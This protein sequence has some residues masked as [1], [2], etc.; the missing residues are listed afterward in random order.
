MSNAQ[1]LPVPSQRIVS[2]PTARYY[3][4]CHA[5]PF[6]SHR[7]HLSLSSA[8][9]VCSK[10]DQSHAPSSLHCQW[11][12]G[13]PRWRVLLGRRDGTTTNVQSARN[14]PNFFD[15]LNVLQEKFRN[16]N[17]DDTDLV[18][19]QGNQS[20][21][22]YQR[23]NTN[24]SNL[25]IKVQDRAHTFGK[26]QCQFTQQNCTAGQSSGALENLDQV[27][28]KVFDNEY[29]NNLLEGRAQLPSD[30]AGGPRWRVLLG[31]RDGTTTNVQSARNLPNFFD[32]LNVLQE[33]FRNVNLDDTDLVALQGAHT[34]GKVQCQFTQQNCTAGQ[35]SGALEN[36]DQVTPKVFDNKYYNNL[37]EGRAQLPSDQSPVSRLQLA[38]SVSAATVCEDEEGWRTTVEGASWPTR[39]H[40]DQRPERQEPAQLLRPLNVL[41]EKFRNVNL[42][43]TDLVALQGNQSTSTYQRSNTNS[44]N[45]EIKVQDR[46]HTFGKVQCQFTQQNCTAGQ[47]S[48]ALEN[49]DQVT[50]KV[51][52][53]E[54][55]NNLLEG[56]A[57]LPSDQLL[58]LVD[59]Y[60]FKAPFYHTLCKLM[61]ED[62]G[63]GCFF[64]RRDGTTTNVQSARNLP[65]FFDPLNVLQEKFRNV[66]L[67]DT[68]LVA[69]Q[70]AHT[71]GKVQCQ[72]TQQN[73]TAGQSS[74][75]LENLDQVTPKV[76]DNKY[77][78]NL[79]EGRAQLPSDQVM[80][81]DP[82]AAATTAPIVHR[83]ILIS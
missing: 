79:L 37:L 16:V 35:S 72:F 31:R 43:D 28:P 80:L 52:D 21:S 9:F 47:S 61:L 14:L 51:F 63:G 59:S 57:Q 34:F 3:K 42:D 75:A 8:S 55:Y 58:S 41:Q 36:L 70:G 54:Y 53:N 66:N 4:T 65:N 30:Q 73:C 7:I 1:P 69:L 32:P 68:D 78:N 10:H 64:G 62:H 83:F 45:L 25:E 38:K 74:G 60:C 27:T 12:A 26:V 19:L 20:T 77:Y 49:L 24:S 82:S 22:T 23:S 40:D 81:S 13:G 46:A 76:F 11:P 6:P 50:P 15:P 5:H 17:L 56:R 44:S 33:K 71:F 48:G 29:Y 18:A 67:D 39:R 2:A